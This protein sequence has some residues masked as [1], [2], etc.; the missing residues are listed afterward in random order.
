MS[1][2]HD[3]SALRQRLASGA[4]EN[5]CGRCDGQLAFLEGQLIHVTEDGEYMYKPHRPTTDKFL[6]EHGHFP[7]QFAAAYCDLCKP[8]RGNC[9]I[10]EK[11]DS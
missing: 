7:G 1:N 5:K 9:I 11:E 10:E 2:R 4:Q 6:V 3:R 8:G